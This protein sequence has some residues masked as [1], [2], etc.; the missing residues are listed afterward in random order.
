MHR[1]ACRIAT[2]FAPS[3]VGVG[4]GLL[5]TALVAL[6]FPTPAAAQSNVETVAGP[7]PAE[8]STLSRIP[9]ALTD[10]VSGR[11]VGVEGPDSTRWA[12]SLIGADDVESVAF[13]AA[14][15]TFEPVSIQRPEGI[16]PV[17]V[18]LTKEAFLTL[19]RT[20]GAAIVLDGTATELPETFR[21]DMKAVYETVV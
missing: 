3:A 8:E 13:R 11:A 6:G 9:R 10:E 12:V 15:Q 17:S 14:G 19:S 21:E 16:G 5:L 7:G 20:K 1:L 18:Y 4:V 2:G